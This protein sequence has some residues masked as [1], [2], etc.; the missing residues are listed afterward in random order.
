LIDTF[1][2][3]FEATIEGNLIGSGYL[4]RNPDQFDRVVLSSVVRGQ[5]DALNLRVRLSAN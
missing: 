1:E 4:K 3:E 5:I 2:K